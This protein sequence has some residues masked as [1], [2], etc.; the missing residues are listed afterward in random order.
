MSIRRWS[1]PCS[2]TP[3]GRV[4]GLNKNNPEGKGN[5]YGAHENSLLPRDLPF[6]EVIRYLTT[7]LVTRQVFTGAGKIGAE[8]GRPATPFQISQ[9]ADFFEEEVGLETTLKR[10]IINTRDEPHGDPGKY[11]RLHVII[12]DAN[13]SETQTFLKLGSAAL[14][15]AAIEDGALPDSLTLAD[16]VASCWTVSHDVGLRR[17]LELE[18]GGTASALDM[19]WRYLEWLSKY[20]EAE[21]D[22][23]GGAELVQGWEG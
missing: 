10:P 16:P 22:D 14:V 7:F 12:G 2:P 3:S 15:L 11:R 5:P 19:Q 6:G 8:N 18:E 1:T 13:L 9:R 21:L 23:P 20:V 17:A 4:V